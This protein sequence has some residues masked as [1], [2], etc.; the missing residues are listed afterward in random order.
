MSNGKSF[1]NANDRIETLRTK[2][3]IAE[4]VREFAAERQDENSVHDDTAQS[5]RR[6]TDTD[7]P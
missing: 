2:P 1:R 3:E 5:P 4:L 6:V 7:Q